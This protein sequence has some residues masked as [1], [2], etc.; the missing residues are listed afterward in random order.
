MSKQP[1][2]SSFLKRLHD[3][4]QYPA[5]PFGALA[6]F[7]TVIEKARRTVREL[8]RRTPNSQGAKL[9]T[10]STALRA[11]RN[12]HLGILLRCYEAWESVGTCFDPISFERIDFHGLSQIIARLTREGL[13]EREEEE[14]SWTQTEKDN[15]LARCR[16]GRRAWR[17]K[18]PLLSLNAVTDEDGHPWK[19]KMNQEEGFVGIGSLFFKPASRVRDITNSKIYYSMFRKFLTTS[20]WSLIETNL[21]NS[22][23]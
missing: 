5:E 10:A 4:Q 12:R 9:L 21:T 7:K 14:P 13:G 3:G 18:K 20:V 23:P 22:L 17:A 1:V 6:D 2:F 8:S 15:V 19:T 11:N 16:L